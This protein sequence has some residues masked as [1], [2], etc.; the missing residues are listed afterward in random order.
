MDLS[1]VL[2]PRGTVSAQG[3]RAMAPRLS[4]LAGAS[5]ALID[6][7][8]PNADLLLDAIFEQLKS[9]G[10]TDRK[11]YTKPNVGTPIDQQTIEEIQQQADFA[12]AALGDCG[13]CSAGTASDSILLE[14]NGV[15]AVAI[16]TKP[17]GVTAASMARSYGMPTIEF[18][19]PPHPMASLMSDEIVARATELTPELVRIVTGQAH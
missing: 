2:D 3:V 18:L 19:L 9:H 10:V 7:G 1:D 14:G 4:T 17:F 8:K 16:C 12:I 6:N 13:S 11:V 5:I 15:P